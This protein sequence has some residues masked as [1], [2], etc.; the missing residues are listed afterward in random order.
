ML[1]T[2]RASFTRTM[3]PSSKSSPLDRPSVPQ[4]DVPPYRLV[5]SKTSPPITVIVDKLPRQKTFYI[6]SALLTYSAHYFRTA[7]SS[8]FTEAETKICR[9]EAD[10]AYAFDLYAQYLYTNDYDVTLAIS[11]EDGGTDPI[12]FRMQAAA[13]VLGS[14]LFA[15]KFK[16]LVLDKFAKALMLSDCSSMELILDLAKRIY[17]FNSTEDGCEMRALVAQFCASRFGKLQKG[18]PYRWCKKDIEAFM[19]FELTDFTIDVL[20][21][22][23]GEEFSADTLTSNWQFQRGQERRLDNPEGH[24]V[25]ARRFIVGSD[26]RK[27]E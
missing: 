20:G 9:L 21:E 4:A 7:L 6:H 26:S 11:K 13:Y 19:G 25:I 24:G 10:D 22:L 8:K 15:P 23:R 2:P 18:P 17:E 3:P 14:K 12:Y 1:A 27:S 5:H 16:Q